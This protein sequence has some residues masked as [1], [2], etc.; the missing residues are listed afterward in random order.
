MRSFRRPARIRAGG[1]LGLGSLGLG[2]RGGFRAVSA[3]VAADAAAGF[4]G[5]RAL[6]VL[7]LLALLFAGALLREPLAA[8]L[9]LLL[10]L[11]FGLLVD[12]PPLEIV[13]AAK[14]RGRERGVA[15]RGRRADLGARVLLLGW[16]HGLFPGRRHGRRR[17]HRRRNLPG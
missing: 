2:W 16:R 6:L 17:H 13:A 11:L 9:L 5:G 7:V 12:E 15:D 8:V 14:H 1:F 3:E 10:L 4:G